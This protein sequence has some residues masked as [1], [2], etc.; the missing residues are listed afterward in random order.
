MKKYNLHGKPYSVFNI[1]EKGWAWSTNCKKIVAG[2]HYK[3]QVVTAGRSKTVTLIGCAAVLDSRSHHSSFSLVH[4]WS[5]SWYKM[6][7]AEPLA[8]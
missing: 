3:E 8:L 1:D 4:E 7:L 2:K 6:P 5:V